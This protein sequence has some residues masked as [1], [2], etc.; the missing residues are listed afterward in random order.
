[1]TTTAFFVDILPGD[2]STE[3]M[4][5][6]L[7]ASTA[8]TAH[9]RVPTPINT[10]TSCSTQNRRIIRSL[11][12]G[13]NISINSGVKM[14][15]ICFDPIHRNGIELTC[16]KQQIHLVCLFSLV[17]ATTLGAACVV[18]C[19]FCRHAMHLE[20]LRQIGINTRP[21][22][23]IHTTKVCNA[24]QHLKNKTTDITNFDTVLSTASKY[25][26][27]DGFVYNCIMINIDRALYH[28]QQLYKEIENT[29]N[30]RHER[31]S[32]AIPIIN[33]LLKVHIEVLI[34]T[35]RVWQQ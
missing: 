16:C 20:T 15:G 25:T 5:M 23:L 8:H 11:V 19:P 7:S 32:N 28:R 18:S 21:S 24:I 17:P 10:T 12:K 22:A 35:R 9:N 2:M 26:I 14:C 1:M 30:T 34:Q 4:Q 29:L 27:A 33:K 31:N 3:I 6:I 13:N